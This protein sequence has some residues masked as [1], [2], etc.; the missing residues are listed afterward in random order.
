[1]KFLPSKIVNKDGKPYIEVKIR[2]GE[3]KLFS[4]E[5]ISAMILG[6]M[7]ETAESYLGMKIKHAVI[8]VP[9]KL[10]IFFLLV[11]CS[12][13]HPLLFVTVALP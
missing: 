5:E 3:V 7:K 12:S 11:L 6:K 10:N 1:M 8:T 13:P 2:D 9:G 4:P